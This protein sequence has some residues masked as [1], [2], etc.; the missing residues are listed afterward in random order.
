MPKDLSR[1]QNIVITM[2]ENRSFDHILGYL[3]LPDSGHP[4]AAR[5]EGVQHAQTYYALTP[6]PA[7]APFVTVGPRK[8]KRGNS[9]HHRRP[10]TLFF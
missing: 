2:L 8:K 6:A 4:L 1:V 10:I 5:I 3:G 7:E 9:N